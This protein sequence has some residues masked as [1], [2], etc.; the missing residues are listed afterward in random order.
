MSSIASVVTMGFGSYGSVALV[1]TMGFGA[2][3]APIPPMPPTPVI[4]AA[5]PIAPILVA[6]GKSSD[7][8][9]P[10]LQRDIARI[11]LDIEENDIMD[12]MHMYNKMKSEQEAEA[13]MQ[14]V[15]MYLGN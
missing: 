7:G 6:T 2:A 3:V 14:I 5:L 1:V 13:I 12:L 4:V 10:N 11:K 8:P 9:T 15:S